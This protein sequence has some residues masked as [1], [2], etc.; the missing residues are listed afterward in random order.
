M[1]SNLIQRTFG[2]ATMIFEG[3][4]GVLLEISLVREKVQLALEFQALTLAKV[5]FLVFEIY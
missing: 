3:L 2:E 5:I 1:R 4:S